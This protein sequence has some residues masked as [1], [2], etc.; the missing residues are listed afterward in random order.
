MPT[1]ENTML[2]VRRLKV[3][4][5][6][7]RAAD[8]ALELVRGACGLEMRYALI[9]ASRNWNVPIR[10]IAKELASRRVAKHGKRDEWWDEYKA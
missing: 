8:E 5:R 4:S 6:V 3:S 7:E 9:R 10:A 2:S 1:S